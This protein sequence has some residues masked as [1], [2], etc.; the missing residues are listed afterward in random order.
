MTLNDCQQCYFR[1]LKIFLSKTKC[2]DIIFAIFVLS[3][4]KKFPKKKIRNKSYHC[5]A[6]QLLLLLLLVVYQQQSTSQYTLFQVLPFLFVDD[7]VFLLWKIQHVLCAHCATVD[8][9]REKKKDDT[10]K[11]NNYCTTSTSNQ[12]HVLYNTIIQ[13]TAVAGSRQQQY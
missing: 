5:C 6:E 10:T 3:K 11:L 8:K 13:H 2:T 12:Y 4:P 7:V 9:S 1:I